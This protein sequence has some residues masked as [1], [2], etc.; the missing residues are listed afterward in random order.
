MHINQTVILNPSSKWVQPG[1]NSTNPIKTPGYIYE[2]FNCPSCP[3]LPIRVYWFNGA[4]NCYKESDLIIIDEE[5]VIELLDKEL[6]YNLN[7]V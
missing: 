4:Q 5:K 3:S 6:K 2:I 7:G 1:R